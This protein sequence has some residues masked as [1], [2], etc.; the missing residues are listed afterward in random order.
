MANWIVQIDDAGKSINIEADNVVVADGTLHFSNDI[1]GGTVTVALINALDWALCANAAYES[2]ISIME[3][4][5]Q[6]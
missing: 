5:Q 4:D 1:E 6:D 2:A 3:D